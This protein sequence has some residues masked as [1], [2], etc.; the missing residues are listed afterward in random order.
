MNL[1]LTNK[2]EIYINHAI[3][4]SRKSTLKSKHGAVLV[5]KGKIIS[6][7]YNHERNRYG[8]TYKITDKNLSQYI[9]YDNQCACH[10]ELDVLY[11]ALL[12]MPLKSSL[13]KIRLKRS[14]FL[15]V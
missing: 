5:S 4:C 11:K 9:H 8:G 12:K 2:D 3:E 10:A 7:G 1:N 15:Q 6:C 13:F 14:L